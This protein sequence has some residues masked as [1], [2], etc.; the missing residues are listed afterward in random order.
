MITWGFEQRRKSDASVVLIMEGMDGTSGAG[1]GKLV[2]FQH[3]GISKG[4]N[5]RRLP[6]MKKS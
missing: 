6:R 3:D 1:T 5:S 4:W 2:A